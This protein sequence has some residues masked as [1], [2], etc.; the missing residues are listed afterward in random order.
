[1]CDQVERAE[2]G[3][4][5][6][7]GQPEELDGRLSIIDL[8]AADVVSTRPDGGPPFKWVEEGDRPALPELRIVLGDARNATSSAWVDIEASPG[9]G[10]RYEVAP[11]PGDCLLPVDRAGSQL[12]GEPHSSMSRC[13]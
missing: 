4:R 8:D 3:E 7:P 2:V 13:L 5:V 1:M 9:V 11:F 12:G 10:I 6:T